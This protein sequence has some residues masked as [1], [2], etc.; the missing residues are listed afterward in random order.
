MWVGEFKGSVVPLLCLKTQ[1]KRSPML[2]MSY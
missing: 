2:L 1:L